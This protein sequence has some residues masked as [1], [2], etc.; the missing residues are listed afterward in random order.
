M[1]RRA[2]SSARPGRHPVVIG[3]LEAVRVLVA[4]VGVALVAALLAWF[5][6]L[7]E[8]KPL[9]VVPQWAASGVGATFGIPVDTGEWVF[10]LPPTVGTVLCWFLVEH[11]AARTT[12][13]LRTNDDLVGAGVLQARPWPRVSGAVALGLTVLVLV[14]GGAF[15]LG[16]AE[17]S[18]LGIVRAVLLVG[19]AAAVGVLRNSDLWI[20]TIEE[21]FGPD[22][23]DAVLLGLRLAGRVALF[24]L[25]GAVVVLG[26]AL[27]LGWDAVTAVVAGYSS[28]TTAAIGLTVVQ[29][30]FLPTA[31]LL[32]LAWLSGPGFAMSVDVL[33]SPFAQSG[34][35]PVALP[36]LGA[37][38]Q[39]APVWAP[40][41]LLVPLSLGVLAVIGRRA[42]QEVALSD[43]VVAS[44]VLV[45]GATAAMTFASGALGPR[46]LEAFGA[47]PWY[48]GPALGG[49][50]SAG[51][52][53]GHGLVGL[54]RR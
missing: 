46:G 14:L 1:L 40:V 4:C 12:R 38:P 21:R 44:V 30:L 9:S 16:S 23:T 48:A 33:A 43:L 7:A 18:V 10:G 26:V 42:W 17:A 20:E 5:L 2:P 45:L 32:V 25:G 37:V 35:V 47:V 39:P 28:P 34:H 31:L 24:A 13:A 27:A 22:H 15:L 19:S 50:V 52:W 49:L 53:A 6:G 36:A 41:F 8:Q 29:V 54:S 3:A 51:L 11:A